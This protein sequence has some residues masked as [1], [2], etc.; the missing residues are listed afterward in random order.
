MIHA[1]CIY[2]WLVAEVYDSSHLYLDMI[3]SESLWFMSFVST[4]D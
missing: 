2:T 3:S 4:H 1:I